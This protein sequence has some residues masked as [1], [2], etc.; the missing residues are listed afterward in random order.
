MSSGAVARGDVDIELCCFACPA[1]EG[2]LE[3][4]ECGMHVSV[5]FDLH[6]ECLLRVG[7]DDEY[8]PQQR[9]NL[10]FGCLSAANGLKN[11]FVLVQI[12]RFQQV[13]GAFTL[14]APSDS[15]KVGRV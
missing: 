13:I 1:K 8:N 11:A 12:S 5:A 4:M 7:G 14:Q 3:Y 2:L 6:A 10:L 9:P 15:A